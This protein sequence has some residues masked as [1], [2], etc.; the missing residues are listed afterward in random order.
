MHEQR[1]SIQHVITTSLFI[2]YFIMCNFVLLYS[3]SAVSFFKC[4]SVNMCDCQSINQA[5]KIFRVAK[6]ESPFH[7]P[8]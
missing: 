2:P 7:G 3:H 5:S 4:Y 8:L 6:I 1:R